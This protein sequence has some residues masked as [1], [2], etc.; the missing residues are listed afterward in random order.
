MYLFW[1]MMFFVLFE[2]SIIKGDTLMYLSLFLV[3]HMINW[4]LIYIMRLFMVY[5]L[6]YVL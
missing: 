3:S 5:V 2:L 4:L 1:L 6:F